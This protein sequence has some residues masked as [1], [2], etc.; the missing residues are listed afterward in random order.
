MLTDPTEDEAMADELTQQQKARAA[1]KKPN[2]PRAPGLSLR[3]ATSEAAKAYQRYSHGSFSRG[4]LAAAMGLSAASG[5]FLGKVATL[6][7]YGL[8]EDAPGGEKLSD[9]FM[10]LYSSPPGSLAA[11]RSALES[12]E[13]SNVFAR[14]LEQFPIRVPDDSALALRLESQERFNRDRARVVAAAFRQSLSEFGLIDAGGNVLPPR[15]DVSRSLNEETQVETSA[16]L[17]TS[18]TDD[19]KSENFRIEIPLRD[20]RRAVLFLPD[21]LSSTDV[22]RVA[23]VL[24]G[25]V[26]PTDDS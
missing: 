16:A 19:A 20:Q 18:V 25:Y 3:Q 22:A 10:A 21:D 1:R 12:I 8:L 6:R 17:G 4:E 14:L 23:A 7:D 9:L 26:V 15:D 13:K 11:K 2:S 24:R 5:G